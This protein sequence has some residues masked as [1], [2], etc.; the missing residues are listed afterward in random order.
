MPTWHDVR[1]V[2]LE[3]VKQH[4]RLPLDSSCD[5]EAD[6]LTLKLRQAHGLVLDYIARADDDDWTEEMLAWT[7]TTAPPAVQA[8]ILRQVAHLWR[9]RGDDDDDGPTVDGTDL[10]PRVKQ[11]LRMYRD[12]VIA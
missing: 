8:A 9:F 11:L 5:D 7:K 12:P 3:Q 1:I 2:T 4:L 6:D 10:T